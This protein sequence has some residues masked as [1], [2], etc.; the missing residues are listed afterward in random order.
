MTK[1]PVKITRR[2][3]K[4]EPSSARKINFLLQKRKEKIPEKNRGRTNSANQ[5]HQ[6]S[7]ALPKKQSYSII[8]WLMSPRMKMTMEA[9][10]LIQLMFK[11]ELFER[12]VK[13]NTMMKIS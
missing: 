5:G 6:K 3:D 9:P 7:R 4:S 12:T 1:V 11:N 8:L 2:K 10:A 13:K